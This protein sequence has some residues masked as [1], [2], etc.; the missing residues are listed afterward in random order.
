MPRTISAT[1]VKNR[2]GAVVNWV[3]ENQDEVIV[4]SRGEATVVI[5]PY[6]QYEK[7]MNLKEQQ[8]RSEVLDR[9]R[10]LRERSLA[11]NQD[12]TPEEGDALADRFSHEIVEKLIEEGKVRFE[13]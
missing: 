5:M 3:L 9:L 4:E 7:I 13:E 11:R 12:L 8:R 2:L 6:G 10:A 1:E